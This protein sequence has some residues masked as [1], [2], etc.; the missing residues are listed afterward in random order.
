MPP[1][2]AASAPVASSPSAPEA[3]GWNKDFASIPQR[4][5]GG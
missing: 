2:P 5:G 1:L 3:F 4:S